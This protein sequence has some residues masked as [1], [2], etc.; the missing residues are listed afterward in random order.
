L[1]EDVGEEE[2]EDGGF[3]ENFSLIYSFKEV[4]SMPWGRGRWWMW[5]SWPGNG[6]FSYLPPWQRPGWLYGRGYCRFYWRRVRPY[7][8]YY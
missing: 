5:K 1:E 2:V 7:W 4:I 8:G 3:S 6:P